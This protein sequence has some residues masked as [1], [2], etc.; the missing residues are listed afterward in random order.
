MSDR[1]QPLAPT[2]PALDQ[3]ALDQTALD[4]AALNKAARDRTALDLVPVTEPEPRRRSG[5][6]SA[7]R[8]SV[9]RLRITPVVVLVAFVCVL[10]LEGYV[11]G[12]FLADHRI[13]PL[14]SESEVPEKVLSGGPV[15]KTA[16]GVVRSYAMP[17]KVIALTFDD[18]PDPTWTPKILAGAEEEPRRQGQCSLPSSARWLPS[19]R[20]S[21]RQMV[22]EGHEVGPA[23]LHLPG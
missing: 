9:P 12:D 11:H 18:G 4:Q 10:L 5:A 6:H 15:I 2:H 7:A 20:V 17:S 8:R 1:T 23:H 21:V 22:A 3:T 19:T 14:V 13:H 16:G